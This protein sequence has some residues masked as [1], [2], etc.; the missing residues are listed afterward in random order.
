VPPNYREFAKL[1][2]G[3]SSPGKRDGGSPAVRISG[4]R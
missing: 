3:V 2:L 4:D 1:F